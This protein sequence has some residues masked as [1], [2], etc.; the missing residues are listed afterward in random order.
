MLSR[1]TMQAIPVV[2]CIMPGC[3]VKTRTPTPEGMCPENLWDVKHE[4]Y[5]RELRRMRA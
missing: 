3:L 4:V 2:S 5:A 1:Y